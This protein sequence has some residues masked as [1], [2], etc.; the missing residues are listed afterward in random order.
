VSEDAGLNPV[1]EAPMTGLVGRIVVGQILPASAGAQH[2]EDA[3]QHAALVAPGAAAAVG[4]AGGSGISGSNTSHCSSVKRIVQGHPPRSDR[5]PKYTRIYETACT[6]SLKRSL[7]MEATHGPNTRES[8]P[9]VASWSYNVYP[10]Y[11][12]L[13]RRTR[14][15][16]FSRQ[17][18]WW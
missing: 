2:P 3:L 14:Q 13:T 15:C 18:D 5:L 10:L 17:I 4:A 1:L 8:Y 7:R 9:A 12:E 11:T 6:C 16:R